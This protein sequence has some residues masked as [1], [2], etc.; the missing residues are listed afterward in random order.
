MRAA[1]RFNPLAPALGS[2]PRPCTGDSVLANSIQERAMGGSTAPMNMPGMSMGGLSSGASHHGQHPAPGMA[3]AHS[4]AGH[5]AVNLLPEWLGIVGVAIFLLIAISH[6]RHLAMTSGERAPWHACHVLM[7]LGMMFMY[8]PAA[9]DAPAV[10]A[11][12]WRIVF[13]ATGGVVALWALGG[14]R[15]APNLIW[16]LTAVDLGAMV[17][18]WS[19]GAFTASLT[20]VLVT[21]LVAE[22]GLWAIDA[23]RRGDGGTPIIGLTMASAGADGGAVA[24]GALPAALLGDLDIS[25]SM[26]GMTLGMAY[27]FAAMQLMT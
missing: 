22:A 3:L 27:M 9:I 11:A 1:A 2:S 18:M 17:Y 15:R 6:L 26:I 8:A 21:Y 10:P 4:G 19:P 23:Y 12:F 7:A 14:A 25:A 20:W 24:V 5:G 16:L 13:A